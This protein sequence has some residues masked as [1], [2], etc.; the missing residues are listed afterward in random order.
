M[1]SIARAVTLLVMTSTLP[2]GAEETKTDPMAGWKPPVIRNAEKDKKEIAA[3]LKAMEDTGTKGDLEAATALMDFPVLMSTDD[4]KGEASAETWTREQW[5][6][7]MKPHYAKPMPPGMVSNGKPTIILVTDSL[8]MVGW[9]WT[10]KMGPKT[11]SGQS[12]MLL[13]RKD[14]AW[15]GK[16]MVEGGWGNAMADSASAAAGK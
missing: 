8:A 2:A 4:S 6:G 16:S 3:F 14:G 12:A 11:L 15:K 13:I 9:P 7:V 10:M 5:V 1:T